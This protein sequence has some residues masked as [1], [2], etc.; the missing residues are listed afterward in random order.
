MRCSFIVKCWLAGSVFLPVPALA[1]N[2]NFKDSFLFSDKVEV[3]FHIGYFTAKA[4]ENVYDNVNGG[5]VSRLIWEVDDAAT[6]NLDGKVKIDDRWSAFGSISYGIDIDN[7]MTDYDFA[8]QFYSTWTDRSTHPKTELDRY[9]SLDVGLEYKLM[10]NERFRAGALG[11]LKYTNIKWTSKGGDYI[12][13]TAPEFGYFRDDTG[14]FD[15]SEKVI[16]YEQTIPV[17]YAGLALGTDFGRWSLDG[18]VLGGISYNSDTKDNH[19]LRSILFEEDYSPAPYLGLQ[20]DA[21]YQINQRVDLFFSGRFDRYFEMKGSILETD[22]V[23]DQSTYYGGDVGGGDLQT[24]NL[25]GGI[26]VRF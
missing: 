9:V 5:Y 4:H 15:D 19:Y 23:L 13:S 1:D 16:S 11:G 26:R 6:L 17:V 18:K 22:T 25:S 20:L 12:Y 14:S 2:Q 21:S 24:L 7:S 10:E 8:N 3:G